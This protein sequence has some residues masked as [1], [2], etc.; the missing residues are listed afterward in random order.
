M[1]SID[2]IDPTFALNM[3]NTID[4]VI[5]TNDN[6]IF[7][8]IGV[9]ISILIIGLILYKIYYVKQCRENSEI[10]CD[11]GFCTRNPQAN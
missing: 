5:S 6:S 4:E 2:I 10:D 8:Y 3:S 1:D 11:G 7:I 9:A